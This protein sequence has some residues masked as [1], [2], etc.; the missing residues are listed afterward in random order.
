MDTKSTNKVFCDCLGVNRGWK[1]ESLLLRMLLY[2][3]ST[4]S[5]V[6]IKMRFETWI[7]WIYVNGIRLF[8]LSYLITL[9]AYLCT[10]RTPKDQSKYFMF[11]WSIYR[12]S[13]TN[14]CWKHDSFQIKI[15]V[16]VCS[17]RGIIE[18]KKR[19]ETWITRNDLNGVNLFHISYL[20][21]KTYGL[22]VLTNGTKCP[23]Q[24][25]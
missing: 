11:Q 9:M 19:L 25:V 1:R 10:Q 14:R 24:V 7:T 21:N 5:I 16:Y 2:V 18:L 4:W 23:N 20:F 3:G 17:T 12:L 13:E 8:Q 22:P 6:E 15:S